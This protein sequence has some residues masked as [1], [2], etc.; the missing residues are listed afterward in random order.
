C[1]H[2]RAPDAARRDPGPRWR[3]AHTQSAYRIFER[4]A[5]YYAV[6]TWPARSSPLLKCPMRIWSR[7]YVLFAQ[8]AT[9]I[10]RTC[11]SHRS[12]SAGYTLIVRALLST[13]GVWPDWTWC[14]RIRGQ[15]GRSRVRVAG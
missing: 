9:L 10:G 15:R 4:D 1:Q 8:R 14:S 7:R 6:A 12:D 3:P 2:D 11:A 13:L 5:H